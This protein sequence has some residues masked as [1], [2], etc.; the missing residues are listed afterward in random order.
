M[1]ERNKHI[2]QRSR[3]LGGGGIAITPSSLQ[4][5]FQYKL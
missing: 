4:L 1:L 2:Y 3:E 5:S